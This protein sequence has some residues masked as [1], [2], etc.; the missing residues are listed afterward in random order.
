M[1]LGHALFSMEGSWPTQECHNDGNLA[2]FCGALSP[3]LEEG[4]MEAG[5]RRCFPILFIFHQKVSSSS[6][7]QIYWVTTLK[8]LQGTSNIAIILAKLHPRSLGE[9]SYSFT[10]MHQ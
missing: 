2:H 5:A 8:M 6:L 7:L 10:V 3:I 4:R 1:T 9:S